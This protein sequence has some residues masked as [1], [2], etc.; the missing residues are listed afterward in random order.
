[1]LHLH[2]ELEILKGFLKAQANFH[3]FKKRKAREN[4]S[5]RNS[6]FNKSKK[7]A[8]PYSVALIAA[9]GNRPSIALTRK[10]KLRR[11]KKSHFKKE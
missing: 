1:M 9:K 2:L 6:A 11:S 10:T 8:L 4:F 5:S 7:D 3:A